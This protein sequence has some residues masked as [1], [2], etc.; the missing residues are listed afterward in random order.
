MMGKHNVIHENRKCIALSSEEDR[1]MPQ[2]ECT[3]NFVKFGHALL[4]CERTNRQTDRHV[5]VHGV[6]RSSQN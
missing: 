3:E 6:T 2:L 5:Y 1:A 4:R